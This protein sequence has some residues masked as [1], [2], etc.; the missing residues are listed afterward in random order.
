[1]NSQTNFLLEKIRTMTRQIENN[2]K[3]KPV[4]NVSQPSQGIVQ[5][6]PLFTNV[7]GGIGLFSSRSK[8]VKDNVKLSSSSMDSL[9]RGVFTCDM[10]WLDFQGIDTCICV[11]G[12]KVC[13]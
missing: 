2:L 3:K 12:E 8:G 5:E 1:M 11:D 7:D 13:F 4:I 10:G 6:K 9:W